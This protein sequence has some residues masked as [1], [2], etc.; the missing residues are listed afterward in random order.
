M[1]ADSLVA[2]CGWSGRWL[3]IVWSLVWSL[4]ADGLVAGCGLS[5]R[6]LQ[7]VWSLVADGLVADTDVACCGQVTLQYICGGCSVPKG[8]E[9]IKSVLLPRGGP[10]LSSGPSLCHTSSVGKSVSQT[11]NDRVVHYK[12]SASFQ[13]CCSTI[14]P[15]HRGQPSVNITESSSQRHGY[16]SLRN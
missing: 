7:M 16:K 5:G 6:L 9:D 12:T 14:Q 1:V 11:L 15:R 2:G 4:V 8:R 13:H 3:R 10:G